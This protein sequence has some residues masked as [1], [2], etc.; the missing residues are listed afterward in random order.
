M[1]YALKTGAGT[2]DAK[3]DL[4]EVLVANE[5]ATAAQSLL[6]FTLSTTGAPAPQT[7]TY[8][9]TTRA[10]FR[11]T[12]SG[13]NPQGLSWTGTKPSIAMSGTQGIMVIAILNGWGAGASAG[14]TQKRV[15]LMSN[16]ASQNL[17]FS[18]SNGSDKPTVGRIG[19]DVHTATTSNLG[20]V[21]SA[22]VLWANDFGQ[23]GSRQR[24]AATGSSLTSA[25]TTS[26]PG[27]I[28]GDGVLEYVGGVAADQWHEPEIFALVVLRYDTATPATIPSDA[29]INALVDDWF[30]T[31]ID[32]PAA[33]VISAPTKSDSGN[34]LTGGFTSN[35]A[36][37]TARAVWIPIADA[38]TA[39]SAAQ[40]KAG[41]NAAGSSTG[42]LAPATL[43]VGSTSPVSFADVSGAVLGTTYLGW[44]VQT[45]AS[46][47][48]NVLALG[49]LYPGTYR[50]VSEVGSSGFTPTGAATNAAAL[51]EDAASDAEYLTTGA[52]NSTPQGITLQLDKPVP[53]GTR[54]ESVRASVSSGTGFVRVT[55]LN[56]SNV[57][58]GTSADQPITATP[59][60]YALPITT[61]GVATRKK[62]DIWI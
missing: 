41:Q 31:L 11:T 39:P 6:G 15:L 23:C 40:V 47:D 4:I 16:G 61:T 43:T 10:F 54:S 30:G 48:S 52:L 18:L 57:V 17:A 14:G 32:G 60:T 27:F 58:Q 42:V 25:E 21:Q 22:Y 38:G 1:P 19:N 50:G 28:I 13:F 8:N 20:D 5:G 3:Y 7:A 35:T 55:L 36:S 46:L 26:D 45:D 62:I 33:P 53:V 59:T 9:G 2:W 37:G 44:A 49:A 29:D 12:G 24:A 34:T 56:D 51:I